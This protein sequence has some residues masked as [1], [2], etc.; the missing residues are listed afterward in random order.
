MRKTLIR[1]FTI[2]DYEDEEIWLREKH[3][4]GWKLVKM[5]P[6]CFYVFESCEPQDVIYRLD[7]KNSQQTEEYM[8]M[9]QDFGW[10]YF[11]QCIGWLYFRKPASDV[12][13]EEDGE[14]F[15]DNV[16]RVDM[17]SNVVKTRLGPLCIIFFCCLLPNL[18]NAFR[19]AN[20]SALGLACA[21]L[22]GVL[23]AIYIFLIIYC[24][25][26]LNRIKKKY[27]D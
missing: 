1:F 15:S 27:T 20:L 21:I 9:L 12:V 13:S 17:V 5:T 8:Q 24:S 2:A 3:R 23:F 4:S 16:S 25:V 10:E 6:P 22:F 19:A 11:E 14:L 7:Y 26:K 18:A